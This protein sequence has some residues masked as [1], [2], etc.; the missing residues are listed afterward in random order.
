MSMAHI[1]PLL[2]L[3]VTVQR[4]RGLWIGCVVESYQ[5]RLQLRQRSL[6]HDLVLREWDA[7]GLHWCPNSCHAPSI[8][9]PSGGREMRYHSATGTS[10]CYQSCCEW[11]LSRLLHLSWMQYRDFR[12]GVCEQHYAGGILSWQGRNS[13]GR[14]QVSILR[15][16]GRF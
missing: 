12:N 9:A 5:A 13:L 2:L 16:R 11:I 4:T 8:L 15:S 6:T 3:K 1:V 7:A 10:R 14:T